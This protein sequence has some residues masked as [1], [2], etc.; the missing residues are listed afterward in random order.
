MTDLWNLKYKSPLC[1]TKVKSQK[2]Q[3]GSQK[4]NKLTY[5]AIYSIIYRKGAEKVDL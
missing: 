2:Q 4:Y 1:N 5:F 3:S